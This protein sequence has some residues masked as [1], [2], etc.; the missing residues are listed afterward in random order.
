MLVDDFLPVFDISDAVATV[1]QADVAATWDALME[2]DLIDVGRQRPLIAVLGAL[3]GLPDIVSHLLHG[4]APPQAPAHLRLRD[5]AT[6]PANKGGWILLGERPRDEIALGLVGPQSA[7]GRDTV[8]FDPGEH[9]AG[10]DAQVGRIEAQRVTR[11]VEACQAVEGRPT[12][13]LRPNEVPRLGAHLPHTAVP[14]RPR[15][16]QPVTETEHVGPNRR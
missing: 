5:T 1:V 10:G 14:L 15:V 13:E 4:E 7:V 2:V 16:G 8:R 9:V 11:R 12:R 3:R 6:M